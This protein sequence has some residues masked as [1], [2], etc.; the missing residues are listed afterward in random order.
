LSKAARDQILS[1]VSDFSGGGNAVLSRAQP[2]IG[3]AGHKLDELDQ[4]IEGLAFAVRPIRE[5]TSQITREHA[6]GPRGAFIL[7]LIA[8]GVCYPLELATALKVGRSL[9]TAELDKLREAGLVT[10]TQGE[11]DRRRS[12]LA[13]TPEGKAAGKQVRVAMRKIV[14]SNL[15]DYSS[16]EMLLFAKMLRDARRVANVESDEDS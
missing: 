9:I 5:A 16:E 11:D 1:R 12:R 3:P 7:R 6:L 10:S 2:D 14:A 4:V 8:G 15:A 13:L